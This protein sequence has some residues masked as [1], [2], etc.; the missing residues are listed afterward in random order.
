MMYVQI[1]TV[2]I[3]ILLVLCLLAVPASFHIEAASRGLIL[4]QPI[5]EDTEPPTTPAWITATPIVATQIDVAWG[6]STDNYELGG[7]QIFRD[8]V[9]VAT[10]TLTSFSDTGLTASTTYL[11]TVR[12]FD[13]LGN[14]STTTGPVATTTPQAA[15]TSSPPTPTSTSTESAIST[16]SGMGRLPVDIEDLAIES[17][18]RSALLSWKTNQYTQYSLR[19]GR[20]GSYELGYVAT[21]LFARSHST[22]IGDLE[23]GTIYEY[24]LIAHDKIGRDHLIS[25]GQFK[26]LS[27]PDTTAPPNVSDFKAQVIGDAVRLMWINPDVD[28]LAYVRIVR[29][30]QFYP[31]EPYN[32]YIVYQGEG[33]SILDQEAFVVYDRQYYTAFVYDKTGNISSGAILVVTKQGRSVPATRV[34]DTQAGAPQRQDTQSNKAEGNAQASTTTKT[35]STGNTQLDTFSFNDI[36][37][38][39]DGVVLNDAEG[40]LQVDG[41]K[42]L[43]VQVP[44]EVLPEHLKSIV[45]T[46]THPANDELAS[47][48]LLRIN[49]EKTAYEAIVAPFY[50]Q[51]LFKVT[52]AVFDYQDQISKEVS[53]F[54]SVVLDPTFSFQNNMFALSPLRIFVIC[55]VLSFIT[56]SIFYFILARRRRRS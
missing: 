19:W 21:D 53:G 2:I 4:S 17:Q 41:A 54:L 16:G 56:V 1:P 31:Q 6:V 28:D 43:T 34:P 24:E 35:P 47:T 37:F 9:Q 14:F 26:T 39:Q 52:V 44:Y 25:R 36:A 51:G 49:K 18:E 10:T 38:I 23:P 12:A 27:A 55:M 3:R 46:F 15:A 29:N 50:E 7:Y 11:Y 32:G 40:S 30:F 42:P 48:F 5:F 13:S 8:A 20:T 33:E 45:V 22:S